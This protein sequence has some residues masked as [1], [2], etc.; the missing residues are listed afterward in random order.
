M[1]VVLLVVYVLMC[2]FV[3]DLRWFC[4]GLLVVGVFG[5]LVLSIL[6]DC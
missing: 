1:L 5:D 4:L 2:V 6:V 3:V